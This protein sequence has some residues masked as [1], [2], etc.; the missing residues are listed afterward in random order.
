MRDLMGTGHTWFQMS[1]A[2]R[3]KMP[4][5][6][7]FA[8]RFPRRPADVFHTYERQA[9]SQ[10]CFGRLRRTAGCCSTLTVIRVRLSG[11]PVL[12]LPD[13]YEVSPRQA[14]FGRITILG[15]RLRC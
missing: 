13:G 5:L 12:Y 6:A 7:Q 3:P 11:P 15:T 9:V 8:H 2:T 10:S 4:D 1:T 14:R